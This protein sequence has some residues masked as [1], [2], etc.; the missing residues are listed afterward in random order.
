[1]TFT[2]RL[3]A[4]FL[5]SIADLF[6]GSSSVLMILILLAHPADEQ[7]VQRFVDVELWCKRA[8]SAWLVGARDSGGSSTID[9]WLAHATHGALLLRVGMWVGRQEMDCYRRFERAALVHNKR[10]TR[11]GIVEATVAPVLLPRAPVE[12]AEP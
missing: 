5:T 9:E 8:G 6:I 10:L 12:H 11:R 2:D 7:R 4:S 3:R 1:M